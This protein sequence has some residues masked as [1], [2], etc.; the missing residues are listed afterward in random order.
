MERYT[1]AFPIE[2]VCSPEA[3]SAFLDCGFSELE[4]SDSGLAVRLHKPGG[5]ESDLDRI[6]D[7]ARSDVMLLADTFTPPVLLIAKTEESLNLNGG[8]SRARTADLLLVRQ[9]L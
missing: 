5:C 7:L 4:R 2:V 9:A 3:M 1:Q 6:F 8:R